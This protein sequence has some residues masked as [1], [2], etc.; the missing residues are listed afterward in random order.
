MGPFDFWFCIF[1][2]VHIKYASDVMS[3]HQKHAHAMPRKDYGSFASGA[4]LL[5]PEECEIV[6]ASE[7]TQIRNR[8]IVRGKVGQRKYP[9]AYDEPKDQRQWVERR[10]NFYLKDFP[11]KITKWGLSEVGHA[12]QLYDEMVSWKPG[13]ESVKRD[14]QQAYI[15]RLI[16]IRDRGLA[17]GKRDLNKFPRRGS[18]GGQQAKDAMYIYKEPTNVDALPIWEEI[19]SWR[20]ADDQGRTIFPDAEPKS[21]KRKKE[22]QRGPSKRQTVSSL[23]DIEQSR[24]RLRQ[25]H[26]TPALPQLQRLSSIDNGDLDSIM[27][28]AANDPTFLEDLMQTDP[29]LFDQH[30]LDGYEEHISISQEHSQLASTSIFLN[31]FVILILF[32]ILHYLYTKIKDLE[33]DSIYVEL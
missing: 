10:D 3:L 14:R 29:S 8:G 30:L 18:D 2:L 33:E 6:A 4:V 27:E 17:R 24:S 26:Q 7:L 23:Q 12:K 21:K 13:T 32:F 9:T 15:T 1:F 22:D 5:S 19:M 28:R 11:A 20:I 31:F 16:E 25:R